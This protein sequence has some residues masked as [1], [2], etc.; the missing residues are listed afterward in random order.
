[1]T[2]TATDVSVATNGDIRW[3]AGGAGDGPYTVLELHRFLQDLADQAS[4]SGDDVVDITSTNPSERSTDNIISLLG[5]YNTDDTMAE[6]CM[7]GQYHR[8]VGTHC[9]LGW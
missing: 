4:P 5:S 8:Q 7:M 3:E 1:M 2:I 9:T 6:T